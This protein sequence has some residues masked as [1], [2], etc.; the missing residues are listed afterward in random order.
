MKKN[1]MQKCATKAI[2]EAI[3]SFYAALIKNVDAVSIRDVMKRKNPYLYKARAVASATEIVDAVLRATVSSSEETIFGNL[4]FEP[5][6]LA[7]SGGNKSTA[8][9]LDIDIVHQNVHEV[10]GIAVKSGTSVFNS[11]SKKRQDEDMRKA[12]TRV[13]QSKGM[14]FRGI[15]GYGYGKK[16]S[17]SKG[18]FIFEELAGQAFWEFLTGDSEFYKKI[19]RYMHGVPEKFAADFKEH[20][21]M[22]ENRLIK[23][24]VEAFC[25]EDGSIDWDKLIEFN[26]GYE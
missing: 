15:V 16:K 17:S 20:Y 19:A 3:R 22:A 5:L 7:V 23:Q 14:H 11:A 4:F 6:A 9:G 2:A 12:R 13:Q 25:H 21:V 24:F 1:D 26:S 18:S 10:I 8:E